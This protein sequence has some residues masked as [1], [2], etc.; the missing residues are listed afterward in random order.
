MLSTSIISLCLQL[1]IPCYLASH[2]ADK[3]DQISFNLY[4]AN[5]T[6]MSPKFKSTMTIFL[7][8]TKEP[9]NMCTAGNI[10]N[11]SLPTF[12]RVSLLQ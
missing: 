10:F 8:A 1:A 4:E 11:I 6:D 3:T 9:F 7:G 5:W 2:L 12:V